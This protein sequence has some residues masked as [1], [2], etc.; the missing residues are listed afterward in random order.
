MDYSVKMLSKII[1]KHQSELIKLN[2]SESEMY[3]DLL[4][5]E[6]EIEN[7]KSCIKQLQKSIKVLL[8]NK[9]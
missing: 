9:E 2:S 8:K 6:E 3:S 5:K 4:F 7:H 1:E